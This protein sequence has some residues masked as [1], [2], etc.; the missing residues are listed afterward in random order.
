MATFT[1]HGLMF[2][3]AVA[4]TLACTTSDA[5]TPL[6][7]ESGADSLLLNGQELAILDLTFSSVGIGG[8]EFADLAEIRL[9]GMSSSRCSSRSRPSPPRRPPRGDG[10]AIP[11]QLVQSPRASLRRRCDGLLEVRRSHEGP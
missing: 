3:T 8:G 5:N 1:A 4:L 10:D 2:F 11:A 9:E 6:E 7:C